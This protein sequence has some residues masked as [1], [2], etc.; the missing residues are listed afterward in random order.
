MPGPLNLPAPKAGDD[1]RKLWRDVISLA[2]L[3]R[4]QQFQLDALKARLSSRRLM[5]SG[6]TSFADF[7]SNAS[8]YSPGSIVQITTVTT[9]GGITILP[10]T[11]V[12]RQG[13]SV[14]ANCTG[15]Q[16][17][18]YPY[19]TSGTIYWICIALGISV[20]PACSGGTSTNIYINSSAGL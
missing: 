9:V 18:Q 11:Y 13:Q 8:A 6:D 4:A 17:P 1:V 2:A 15:N 19:P 10:G 20:V 5:D 3:A 12:L 16:I 14:P 7:Y